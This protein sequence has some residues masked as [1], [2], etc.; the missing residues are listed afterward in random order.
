MSPFVG[1]IEQLISFARKAFFKKSINTFYN[2]RQRF[3]YAT[4]NTQIPPIRQDIRIKRAY[5]VFKVGSI[6]VANLRS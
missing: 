5:L 6:N 4:P 1:F 3:I 2:D